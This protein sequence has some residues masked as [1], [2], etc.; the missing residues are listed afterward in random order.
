MSERTRQPFCIQGSRNGPAIAEAGGRRF[1]TTAPDEGAPAP[2][3]CPILGPSAAPEIPPEIPPKI[4]PDDPAVSA[5]SVAVQDRGGP[6]E[7]STTVLAAVSP[8]ER[9]PPSKEA[10]RFPAARF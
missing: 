5:R 4:L 10:C 7:A 1:A 6:S 9:P 3:R 2:D 8:K